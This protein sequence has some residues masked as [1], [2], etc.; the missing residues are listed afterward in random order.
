M[1]GRGCAQPQPASASSAASILCS[2]F[3]SSPSTAT[4][5]YAG[6]PP[7][8]PCLLVVAPSSRQFRRGWPVSHS[9]RQIILGGRIIA[10]MPRRRSVCGTAPPPITTQSSLSSSACYCRLLLP[11]SATGAFSR[12]F[13]WLNSAFS[14][15]NS[16][17]DLPI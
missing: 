16:R 1:G 8:A 11:P 12:I 3:L 17:Q 13:D 6:T 9:T 5:T 15:H 10:L 2:L 7:M 14:E 4:S